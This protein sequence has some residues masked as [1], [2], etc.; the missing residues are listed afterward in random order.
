[1]YKAFANARVQG[2]VRMGETLSDAL[3]DLPM[4]QIQTDGDFKWTTASRRANL[5]GKGADLA[6]K[7][8]VIG[9]MSAAIWF[10]NRDD[11][12]WKEKAEWEKGSYWFL[13]IPG[14]DTFFRFAKPFEWGAAANAVEAM[15]TWT[16]ER[17]PSRFRDMAAEYF[18]DWEDPD[19][20]WRQILTYSPTGAVPVLEIF[21]NYDAFRDAPLWNPYERGGKSQQYSRWTSET[22]KLLQKT[23]LTK[24]NPAQIDHL[25]TGWTSN[26]GEG[27][28]QA[29]DAAL[30][31]GGYA[32]AKDA[33]SRSSSQHALW[34]GFLDDA[35][36]NSHSKSIQ[37]LYQL[38]EMAEIIDSET[39][40]EVGELEAPMSQAE[41]TEIKDAKKAFGEIQKAVRAIY[42]TTYDEMDAD[43][44]SEALREQYEEMIRIA[45]ETFATLETLKQERKELQEQ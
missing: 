42:D 22:A 32:P 13:K 7:L 38:A 27:V 40:W 17:D 14:T 3:Q 9:A 10:R 20:V 33:P 35:N 43:A 41:I 11:E 34:G 25:I 23:F 44:K 12:E 16:Y 29:T 39:D 5:F 45:N 30:A 21:S 8:G 36:F 2:W 31:A 1:M 18:P 4:V 37:K 19:A 26:F 6:F 15:L 28:L 24:L